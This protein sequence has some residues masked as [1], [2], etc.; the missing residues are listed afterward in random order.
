MI[1]KQLRENLKEYGEQND[2]A[3]EIMDN[4]S[5]DNSIVGITTEHKLVYDYNKM[6][7]EYMKDEHCKREV[8]I[9]FI[10]YNTMRDLPYRSY[11]V[12][13]PIKEIEML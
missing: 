13:T 7:A 10:N 6:V 8:A 3:I 11:I 5:F 4:P 1:N 9:E 12:I 2:V